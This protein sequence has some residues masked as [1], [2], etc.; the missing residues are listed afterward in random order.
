VLYWYGYSAG[1]RVLIGIASMV[2]M[3]V[4]YVAGLMSLVAGEEAA[5]V[6]G[7]VSTYRSFLQMP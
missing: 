4:G 2:L 6:A 1:F 7:R 3:Q 5:A